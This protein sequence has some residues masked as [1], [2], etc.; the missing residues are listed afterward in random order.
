LATVK[1]K[2]CLTATIVYELAVERTSTENIG[3]NV[4]IFMTVNNDLAVT[5]HNLEI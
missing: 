1:S 3:G 4:Q 5:E 2:I